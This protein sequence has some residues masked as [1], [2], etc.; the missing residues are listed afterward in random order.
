M[1]SVPASAAPSVEGYRSSASISIG[2]ITIEAP[3]GSNA[4]DIATLVRLELARAIEQ[5]C[6]MLGVNPGQVRFV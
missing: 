3:A 2:P 4:Q 5:T 1:V 6:K